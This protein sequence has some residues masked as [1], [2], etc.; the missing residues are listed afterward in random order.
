MIVNWLCLCVV[1]VVYRV[2]VLLCWLSVG[3]DGLYVD[4][5]LADELMCCMCVDCVLVV[6]C[7][8]SVCVL[9]MCCVCAKYGLFVR[10]LCV[11]CV[12]L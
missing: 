6:R 2:C 12:L 5:V 10:W 11:D 4:C 9:F 7:V 8:C 3:S 1:L